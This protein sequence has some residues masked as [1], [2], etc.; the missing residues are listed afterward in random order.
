MPSKNIDN[1]KYG[2][3]KSI[4]KEYKAIWLQYLLTVYK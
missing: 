4:S 1:E 2:H 3:L